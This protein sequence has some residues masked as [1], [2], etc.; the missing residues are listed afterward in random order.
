MSPYRIEL[1]AA[2]AEFVHDVALRREQFPK[3]LAVYDVLRIFGD[4]VVTT[5]NA[6]W[7][8]HRRVT[9]G[10]FNERNAALVFVEAISQARSMLSSWVA[11][12][13]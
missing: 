9:A 1:N 6:L 2:N 3:D 7:R 4:N 11:H 10:T 8:M 12:S 5:E 13:R